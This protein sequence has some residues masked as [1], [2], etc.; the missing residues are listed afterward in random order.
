MICTHVIPGSQCTLREVRRSPPF[1]VHPPRHACTCT[2]PRCGRIGKMDDA[3]WRISDSSPIHLAHG[4]RTRWW[5]GTRPLIMEVAK[6]ETKRESHRRAYAQATRGID[7]H[8]RR[9]SRQRI[10][11]LDH[12][13]SCRSLD[14]P[15][16]QQG[17]VATHIF[18]PKVT[19]ASVYACMHCIGPV[20]R[21]ALFV[22]CYVS[23][24][25]VSCPLLAWTAL[26]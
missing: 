18:W 7:A 24:V 12:R 1:A 14:L 22:P 8:G 20:T 9:V 17:G 13:R 5:P 15:P 26:V 23:L 4:I 11:A 3:Q 10:A 21:R 6:D 2:G 16:F 25:W 19:G